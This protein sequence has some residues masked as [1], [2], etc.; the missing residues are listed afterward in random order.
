MFGEDY[1]GSSTEEGWRG[2]DRGR[3]SVQVVAIEEDEEGLSY[4]GSARPGA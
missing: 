1:S 3:I 4:Q 2:R